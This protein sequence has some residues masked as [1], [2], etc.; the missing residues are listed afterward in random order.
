VPQAIT[1]VAVTRVK[2]PYALSAVVSGGAASE[3]TVLCRLNEMI[4]LCTEPTCICLSATSATRVNVLQN[5]VLGGNW[6]WTESTMPLG[7]RSA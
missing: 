1:A 7:H 4:N 5:S 3:G 6:G 2:L